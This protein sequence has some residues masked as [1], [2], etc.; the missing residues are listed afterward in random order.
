AAVLLGGSLSVFILPKLIPLFTSLK[1]ELPMITKMLLAISL[2]VQSSWLLGIFLVFFLIVGVVLLNRIHRI[3]KIFHFIFIHLPFMGGMLMNYQRALVSQL[4]G[5]LLK[6]GLSLNDSASIVS[7]AVTNIYYQDSIKLIHD[8][9]IKGT[10]LSLSMRHFGRL[11]PNMMISV[12]SIGENSGSLVQSFEYLAEFYSK[13][14]STQAKKLP[15]VIEPVL[16]VLIAVIVGFVALAI[17]M[18]I[19]ELTGSL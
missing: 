5:T 11:F 3:R 12:V 14:V 10:T 1:V 6:S 15:T 17:I 13:E 8:Q 9:L 18:P 19:Y 2:W 7:G 16:L 4:F